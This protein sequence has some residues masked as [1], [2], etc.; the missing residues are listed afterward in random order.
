MALVLGITPQEFK[1]NPFEDAAGWELTDE[2]KKK[3]CFFTPH[4][5]TP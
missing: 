5:S 2:G 4:L 3:A 1:L